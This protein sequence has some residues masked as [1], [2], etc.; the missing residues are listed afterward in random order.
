VGDCRTCPLW[1]RLGRKWGE[2]FGGFNSA[3]K[4]AL[5]EGASPD[6]IVSMADG[7]GTMTARTC[8][9]TPKVKGRSLKRVP[10]LQHCPSLLWPPGLAHA[11]LP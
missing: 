11:A 1:L 9:A 10:S 6:T 4:A 7:D 2:P 5:E 3:V 8:Y